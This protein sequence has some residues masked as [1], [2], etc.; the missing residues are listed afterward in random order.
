MRAIFRS[1]CVFLLSFL[2]FAVISLHAQDLTI[3]KARITTGA[4][5]LSV[6]PPGSGAFLCFELENKSAE[7]QYLI[8]SIRSEEAKEE[9]QYFSAEFLAPAKSVQ[10]CQF[11][12]QLDGSR[13]YTISSNG[14]AQI[15][16]AELFILA[17][18][19]SDRLNLTVT[20]QPVCSGAS[21]VNAYPQLKGF[22]GRCTVESAA[23]SKLPMF[24]HQLEHYR[25]IL[26]YKTDFGTWHAKSFDAVIEYVNNGGTLCFG[27]PQDA[28][29][30]LQTPLKD[31][32]PLKFTEKKSRR[33]AAA[34][35]AIRVNNRQYL[36]AEPAAKA[37]K[38]RAGEYVEM[39]Y[40]K[41]VVRASGVDIWH[42]A[43]DSDGKELGAFLEGTQIPARPIEYTHTRL[44]R[45][46]IPG[47]AFPQG[48]RLIAVLIFMAFG[49]LLLFIAEIV[50]R[51][52]FGD[53]VKK[54]Y[55]YT[56]LLIWCAGILLLGCI[57]GGVLFDW[58]PVPGGDTETPQN[59]EA[60][61]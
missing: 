28:C 13:S 37:K 59:V 9:D 49:I 24:A 34:V 7:D 61:K 21:H 12:F 53:K 38:M 10:Q 58:V 33:T 55:A 29:N 48:R 8:V 43:K 60:G 25:T 52:I 2:S 47:F 19:D 4:K 1:F 30:A 41:G 31:L 26:L 40:G 39:A 15:A 11:P 42:A 32:V 54:G 5:T 22:P 44:D 50:L 23:G 46:E 35:G 57:K 3:S 6:L 16:E 45:N 20:D 27:T 18:N 36:V 17:W 56:A 14:K 51:R